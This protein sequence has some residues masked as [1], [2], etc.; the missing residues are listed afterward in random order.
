M[1]VIAIG[2]R[3]FADSPIVI[4]SNRDE[5]VARPTAPVARWSELPEIVAG[6]DLR[7]G[8]TWL[9]V[10]RNGRFAAITNFRDPSERVDDARSRGALP[11][12][13]LQSLKSPEEF[14][15]SIR[16]ARSRYRGFLLLA[17]DDDAAL[18]YESRSDKVTPLRAGVTAFSNGPLSAPWPK[19]VRLGNAMR[20]QAPHGL[21]LGPAFAAL[22]D[23]VLAPEGDLPNT[24][25]PPAVEAAL[26]SVFIAPSAVF[27]APYQTRAS[28]VLVRDRGG[29]Q[30]TERTHAQATQLRYFETT[31]SSARLA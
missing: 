22:A 14:F 8:G 9:G 25:V 12:A 28:T 4:W 13:F 3:A 10:H 11:V 7:E 2:W 17:G 16:A 29:W 6:R 18:V 31:I 1:C 27:S 24:G 5:F 30:I 21:A 23:C 15:G 19:S 26:S 20:A